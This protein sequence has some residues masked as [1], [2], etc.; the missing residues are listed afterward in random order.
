MLSLYHGALPTGELYTQWEALAQS[1]NCGAVS[2][3]SGIVRKEQSLE[4]HLE[5]NL[6]SQLKSQNPKTPTAEVFE[7]NCVEALSFDIYKPLL[8]KWFNSW[9]EKAHN[10]GA[11]V[12]MAHSI[13]DVPCG[14]SSFMCGIISSHRKVALSLYAELIEDFKA[15]APIWKYDVINHKR[16]YAKERS[17]ALKG[18]GILCK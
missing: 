6:D 3:F 8:E 14:K 10:M 2:I 7:D 15:N 1:K 16:I 11:Y 5:S 9:Q 4:S 17:K 18:S 12:C 13:G